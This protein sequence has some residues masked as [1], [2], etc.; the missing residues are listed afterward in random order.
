MGTQ[1]PQILLG[2]IN[3]PAV[4]IVREMQHSPAGVFL[5]SIGSI[6]GSFGINPDVPISILM[7]SIGRMNCSA[8]HARPVTLFELSNKTKVHF[9]LFRRGARVVEWGGLENR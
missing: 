5:A 9:A 3:P 4:I 8:C 6:L 2:E 7:E 1:D